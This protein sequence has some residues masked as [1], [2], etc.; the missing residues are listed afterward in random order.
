MWFE[1]FTGGIE[2]KPFTSVGRR[3]PVLLLAVLMAAVLSACGKGASQSGSAATSG[4]A[5]IVNIGVTDTLG[6]LNPLTIDA[7]EINKYS[8]AMMFL[9]LME[10]NGK[11]QFVGSVADSITVKDNKVFTIHVDPKAKW[12]DG[13]PVTADDVAFTITRLC[14]PVIANATMSMYA[15]EGT[16]D[17][18]FVQKGAQTASGINVVDDKTLTLTMKYPMGLTTFENSYARYIMTVPKHILASVDESKLAKYDWFNHPTVVDGPYIAQSVDVNHFV[19]YVA[20]K[21]YWKGAPKIAKMNIKIVSADQIYSGLKSGEIDFVQPTMAETPQEDYASI[22]KLSN[23]KATYS[24]PV[25]TQSLF[26]NTATIPDVRVRQAI[27]YAINRP[28]LLKNLLNGKG[29]VVDGFVTSVSPYYDKSLKATSYNSEKAKALVKEAGWDSGKTLSFY[30]NSGDASFVNGSSV[31]KEE[32]KAVGINVEIHTVDLATLMAKAGSQGFD[33]LAVQYTYAPV[34]PYPDVKWL[35]SGKG[36]W[37]GFSSDAVNAALEKTQETEDA[38][39]IRQQ[40]L[41][42]DQTVQQQ[43]PMINTYVIRSLGAVS[44]RLK[45]ATSNVYG[46]FI[47]IQ[48]WEKQ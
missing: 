5:S 26:L 11:M 47:N 28:M 43:V 21:S 1:S 30:V 46:S 19:S 36:S 32:L 33:L 18:G 31:I 45:N 44:K 48:N 37:T 9:P 42:I 29:E 20:N 12:S 38:S 15:L 23:V 39:V 17:S 8:T 4:S 41:T 14:S 3:L 34:D 27:Q 22:T 7:T 10:L 2:M 24:D 6:S 13:K 40:Y 25:T 35:L 16:D